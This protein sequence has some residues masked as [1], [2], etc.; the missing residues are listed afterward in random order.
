MKIWTGANVLHVVL[1]FAAV[2]G[3]G[4]YQLIE[5]RTSYSII[6]SSLPFMSV[7][8]RYH[9]EQCDMCWAG[10]LEAEAQ[11]AH[12]PDFHNTSDSHDIQGHQQH[13]HQSNN[14]SVNSFNHTQHNHSHFTP[15]EEQQGHLS[16]EEEHSHSATEG[17]HSHSAVEHDHSACGHNTAVAPWMHQQLLMFDTA[18]EAADA[19]AKTSVKAATGDHMP[20]VPAEIR[21][22]TDFQLNGIEDVSKR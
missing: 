22:H 9:T 18:K 4:T 5:Y 10:N 19:I 16:V 8:H 2:L 15:D 20:P 13:L 12:Q 3:R 6:G 21:I 11:D 14:Q 1:I 7:S 17:N